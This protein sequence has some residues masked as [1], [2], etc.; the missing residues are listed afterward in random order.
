MNEDNVIFDKEK[1]N[2]F[3]TE[4]N[5]FYLAKYEINPNFIESLKL[6]GTQ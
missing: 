3:Y 4:K 2:I 6:I 1:P 5:T